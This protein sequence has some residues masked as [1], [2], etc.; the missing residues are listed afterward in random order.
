MERWWNPIFMADLFP[1]VL[2][3]YG[4]FCEDFPTLCN[5]YIYLCIYCQSLTAL[6]LVIPL[7]SSSL[8]YHCYGYLFHCGHC[9]ILSH[10]PLT[11]T[12][13]YSLFH[14][15]NFIQYS[16]GCTLPFVKIHL[17]LKHRLFFY[18]N[19]P[20]T[21]LLPLFVSLWYFGSGR[22]LLGVETCIITLFSLHLYQYT[23]CQYL[24]QSH[25]RDRVSL[26]AGVGQW[27]HDW[28]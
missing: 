26:W 11:N 3:T 8:F 18:L 2:K 10:F 16:K 23:Y 1:R 20:K 19:P 27:F 5:W 4:W 7:L 21:E 15:T 13:L 25:V 9:H 28:R 24:V 22:Y 14:L 6:T 17:Q 12:V